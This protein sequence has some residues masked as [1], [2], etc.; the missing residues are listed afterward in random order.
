MGE[1]M[2][3]IIKLIGFHSVH[4]LTNLIAQNDMLN[5]FFWLLINKISCE[6]SSE[7]FLPLTGFKSSFLLEMR[8]NKTEKQQIGVG[9]LV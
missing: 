6:S 4:M 1:G 9:S 3:S 8:R 2:E 7:N 5:A